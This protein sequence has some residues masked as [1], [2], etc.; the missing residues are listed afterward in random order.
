MRWIR[1]NLAIGTRLALLALAIQLLVSFSHFHLD[2]IAQASGLS[3]AATREAGSTSK[4]SPAPDR[5]PLCPIC[6]LIQL[7]AATVHPVAP[8]LPLPDL[9]DWTRPDVA[10]AQPLPA[11]LRLPF[12]ARAPPSP[13][14]Q[15]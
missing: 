7:S 13:R 4:P 9:V 5:E 15:S 3:A 2:G 1:T 6:V 8:V 14:N 10:V 12:N 11:L